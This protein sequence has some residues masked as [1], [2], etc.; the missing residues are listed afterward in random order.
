VFAAVAFLAL[1][2]A[3][4]IAGV[5]ADGRAPGSADRIAWGPAEPPAYRESGPALLVCPEDPADFTERNAD[6][7]YNQRIENERLYEDCAAT[8]HHDLASALAA[9][10]PGIT[11][12][13]L[14]GQYATGET[15]LIDGT[16]DLQIE[17]LGDSPEDVLLTARFAADTVLEAHD[18][19]ML[20]L[21]GFTVG[22]AREQGLLLT[23]VEGAVVE[24]V[25]AV[26]SGA[27]GLRIADSPTVHL[28]GCRAEAAD[29]AG[30]SIE[31]ST[32]TVDGCEATGNLIGLR[33]SGDRA[34]DLT[35]NRLH[36]NTTGLVVTG[37][38]RNGVVRAEA[39]LVHDNNTDHYANLGTA[40]C[41][42][43]LAERAWADGVLCPDLT[44]PSGVGILVA[45]AVN[46]RFEANR[47]W[48]QQTAAVAVW[49]S[50]GLDAAGS[51]QNRFADNVFGV[52]EDGQQQRNRL[53]L[54]WDGIGADNCFEEPGTYRTAP[55]VLPGCGMVDQTS[56]LL[57][58]PLRAFKIHQCGIGPADP[59]PA[60]CDW[61]GARFTERLEFQ[62]AVVFAA[63]L[64]FLTGAGWL[65]AARAPEPPRA[66]QMTF[67]AIATG[68][69]GLLLV[70]AVWS[71]RADYEALAIGLWGCGW[72]LAGRSWYR[73]GVPFF[74]S[75][76]AL[77]GAAAVL[78]AID[79]AVWTIA[80]LPLSPA[81]FWLALLPLWTL[82][83]LT[84]AFGPRAREEEPPPVRRTPVTAPAHDRFD[85]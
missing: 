5:V 28:T 39:N 2:A 77:I 52:R 79:R 16:A 57:G 58:D 25:A 51:D 60:G 83:V 21:K 13:I 54:S 80:P 11:V 69:G 66:G 61:L 26:Q 33:A 45:D 7:H 73:C 76:T 75:F 44:V 68:A 34:V 22:Q 55:H 37:T 82:F 59:L 6:V 40:A 35:A 19:A 17:G 12:R 20:Y 4:L 27:Y 47:L 56:R 62:A 70:L 36:G 15:I 43:D 42:K 23:G 85:W 8:G 64:L 49:G 1:G 46:G 38:D 74:G 50:P 71:G 31:D 48:N 32:A 84:V 53:D 30:I 3:A 67:S 41:D 63:A 78:D 29:T 65:G 24:S 9:A 18:A 10:E 14:P 81:W 72:L